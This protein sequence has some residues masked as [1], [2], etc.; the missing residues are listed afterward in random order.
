M[1]RKTRSRAKSNSI[2]NYVA[3]VLLTIAGLVLS[4]CS[5]NIPFT[6]QV[7]N[8]FANSIPLGIDF[9][10]GISVVYD[11]SLGTDSN[12]TN[13]GIA[14]DGTV[15]RLQNVISQEYDDV[16]V[17]RQGNSI[18]VEVPA[19][20]DAN[21]ITKLTTEKTPLK[22]AT[23]EDGDAQFVAT[24]VS[25]VKVQYQPG[26]NNQFGAFILFNNDASERLAELTAD[27]A[28]TQVT[29]YIYLGDNLLQ[30]ITC[31]EQIEVGSPL[32]LAFDTEEQAQ[33][34]AN[35]IM[36]GVFSADLD[37]SSSTIIPAELG[38]QAMNFFLIAGGVALLIVM[39]FLWIRYGD[40]GLLADFALVIYT[41]LM[42]FFMQAIPGIE[43]MLTS[44]AGIL[45]SAFIVIG[46]AVVI[47]EKIRADYRSGMKIPIA[48]KSGFKRSLWP[49]LD[50]HF[51]TL[52]FGILLCVLGSVELQQFAFILLIGTVL[53]LFVNLVVLRYL[54]KWYLPFNSVK[55]K[56]LHMPNQV[57]HIKDGEVIIEGGQANE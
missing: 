16:S 21:A 48:F 24:D 56:K 2:L 31:K 43:L 6:T 36:G 13:L 9:V 19:L 57:K 41:V 50:S 17:T 47:L 34:W 23:E 44:F 15:A 33:S 22:I 51:L 42:L 30:Q 45:F 28:T 26:T 7:Y 40:F 37:L 29:F 4:F 11:C 39:V 12:T 54:L 38:T 8:G 18:R 14:V 3:V 35:Q 1:A 20:S 46:S 32:G 52:L 25:D 55:A 27:A 49:V 5:F 10:G 53:S